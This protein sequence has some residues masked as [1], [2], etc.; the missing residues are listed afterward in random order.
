MLDFNQYTRIT[1]KEALEHPWFRPDCMKMAGVSTDKAFGQV[2]TG[3]WQASSLGAL[4]G[5]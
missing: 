4:N 5:I 2:T 3:T 1:A